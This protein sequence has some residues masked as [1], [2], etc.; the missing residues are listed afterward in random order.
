MVIFGRKFQ[1]VRLKTACN[2]KKFLYWSWK[3]FKALFLYGRK[4]ISPFLQSAQQRSE[5]IHRK[6]FQNV[7]VIL[8]QNLAQVSF[9]DI[10]PAIKSVFF[11]QLPPRRS[12][13]ILEYKEPS[14]ISSKFR[15]LIW[16]N[17]ENIHD[18]NKFLSIR[19]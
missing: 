9:R 7:Y 5:N 16:Q 8:L 13:T 2:E 12:K 10:Q 1:H 4:F 6:I 18:N 11:C 15:H 3:V 17:S 19:S 14:V